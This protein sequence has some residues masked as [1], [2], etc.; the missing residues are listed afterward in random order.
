M[1]DKC[2][3]C[4]TLYKINL[5]KVLQ[6]LELLKVENVSIF[7]DEGNKYTFKN[8]V[9][10][11]DLLSVLKKRECYLFFDDELV[12]CTMDKELEALSTKKVLVDINYGENII[13][14]LV[15]PKN[16][17]ISEEDIRMLMKS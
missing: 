11:V 1:S 14:I 12:A 7:I 10:T 17:D 2:L 5:K 13:T 8:I 3:L 4:F 6:L 9:S 16:T 15:N